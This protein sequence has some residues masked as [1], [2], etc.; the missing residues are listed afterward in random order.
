MIGS[1]DVKEPIESLDG[2]KLGFFKTSNFL[3]LVSILDNDITFDLNKVGDKPVSIKMTDGK[4]K[5][6][7]ALADMSIIPAVP[8]LK[9]VPSEFEVKIK[10]DDYFVNTFTK[11]NNALSDVVNFS[12]QADASN[13]VIVLG[14]TNVNTDTIVLKPTVLETDVIPVLYFIAEDLKR[15]IGANKGLESELWIS[16]EGMAKIVFDNDVCTST[17]YLV[18]G[19]VQ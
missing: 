6:S 1:V 4:T 3:K 9:H 10:L 12:V 17:Y 7:F 5:S 19:N 8:P 15:V 16:K 13:C 2:F 14:D 11:A 18:A